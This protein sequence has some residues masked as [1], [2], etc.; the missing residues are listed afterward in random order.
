ML[1]TLWN[2]STAPAAA[3]T[4]RLA[5]ALAGWRWARIEAD[6]DERPLNVQAIDGASCIALQQPLPSLDCA[7]L[8]ARRTETGSMSSGPTAARS[9]NKE[10]GGR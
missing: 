7:F 3:A 9:Q 1:L 10:V 8:V 4:L 5:P 2:L 6:G